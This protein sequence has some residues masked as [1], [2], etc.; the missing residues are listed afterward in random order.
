[1]SRRAYREGHNHIA[2]IQIKSGSK[3]H[4]L[5]ISTLDVNL[6]ANLARRSV[7]YTG[8]LGTD[9]EG[10]AYYLLTPRVVEEYGRPPVGWASGLVC[11]GIGGGPDIAPAES[12]AAKGNRTQTPSKG[13]GDEKGAE[14]DGEEDELPVT[15][16]RW[17][18]FGTS[19]HIAQLAKWLQA[20]KCEGELVKRVHEAREWVE[21][22]EY[23]GQG[24]M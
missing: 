9:T 17:S 13:R 7:R 12:A 1:M 10:R 11:W 6:R 8:P 2:N 21:V 23:K 5:R 4:Q 15:T 16:E 3:D 18:H 22:L 24:E 19:D 20:N 14:N